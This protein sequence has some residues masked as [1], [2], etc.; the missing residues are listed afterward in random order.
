MV[1]TTEVVDKIITWFA[2][3][4]YQ[5][6]WV[7][8]GMI[9]M[10]LASAFGLPIPEEATLIAAG[11]TAHA[12]LH[13]SPGTVIPE[14]ATP[15]NYITLAVVAF[16]SVLFS[17]LLIY[18]LGR[19]FGRKVTNTAIGKK[20]YT[21]AMQE[22]VSHWIKKYGLLA[23]AVFRFT[24]GVRFPG[25]LMCGALKLDRVK[26]IVVDA[27]VALISVPTQIILVS[28]YGRDILQFLFKI[29]YFIFGGLFVFVIFYYLKKLREPQKS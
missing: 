5:P 23:P 9:T 22:R 29:K 14:G 8:T 3:Y 13:P 4:A 27:F 18:E 25:H 19:Y 20:Y 17:D 12:A 21:D 16:F 15:I 1:D 10:M 7:Y 11:L 2:P 26:F 28:L 24:P 6:G